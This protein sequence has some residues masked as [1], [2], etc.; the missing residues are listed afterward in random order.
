M[1]VFRKINKNSHRGKFDMTRYMFKNQYSS[2]HHYIYIT[3]FHIQ[4]IK[5]TDIGYFKD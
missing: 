2:V 4:S 3:L 1:L 5:E